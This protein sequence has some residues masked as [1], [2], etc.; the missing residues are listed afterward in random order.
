[1][2][3]PLSQIIIGERQ[4][5]DLG[6]LTDLDSMADSDIG[7]INPITVH[8]TLMGYELVDGRR[9]LAKA[10]KLGWT[11]IECFEKDQLT[12]VQKQKM[13]LLADIG[14]KNRS[15]QETCIAVVKVHNMIRRERAATGTD[16]E[17]GRVHSWSI[18]QM[19]RFTGYDRTYLNYMV[20]L[21]DKLRAEPRD[22]ELWACT[23]YTEAIKLLSDRE[24]AAAHK[25]M[26][27]RR[28]QLLEAAKTLVQTAVQG[29][30]PTMPAPKIEFREVVPG[31]GRMEAFYDGVPSA[32][33]HK[34]KAQVEAPAA[35]P[36]GNGSPPAI[37]LALRCDLFNKKYAHLGPPNTPMFHIE[38]NGREMIHG[39]WF[40]GGGNVSDFYGSYQTEYLERVQ[41]MFPDFDGPDQVVHLFSGSL[42]PGPYTRVGIDPTGKYKSDFECDAHKLAAFLPFNPSLI[43][44]DP[45]YSVEDSEHYQNSM[46][47]RAAILE[48][49]G[50]VLKPGGYVVWLDQAL[51]VFSNENLQLVGA[52]GFV[53]STGNRFRLVTLFR[54]AE[55]KETEYE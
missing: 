46:V 22:E 53:R 10:E 55:K 31:S 29:S 41:C 16:S 49:C 34:I 15:W 25:E 39:F 50:L 36:Q 24:F 52:I 1:M 9:R 43:Y 38:A 18:R 7:Q 14:R 13:E 6:D 51:P 4:R 54:K 44:A 35:P 8:K 21:S 19:A 37:T 48:Q 42:P 33:Y 17:D 47:N 28:Q 20:T 27:F 45:P 23:T 11:S 32:E 40:T 12:E 5:I 3:L 30:T 2:K 26:E